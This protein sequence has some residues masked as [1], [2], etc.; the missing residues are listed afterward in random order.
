MQGDN[1]VSLLHGNT[2]IYPTFLPFPEFLCSRNL[3]TCWVG[4]MKS[5][6]LFT[7]SL[8]GFLLSLIM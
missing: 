2:F 1:I 3:Q 7:L 5:W 4:V 8:C 6:E